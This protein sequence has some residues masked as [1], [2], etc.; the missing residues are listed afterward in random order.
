MRVLVIE[1]VLTVVDVGHREHDALQ[2]EHDTN[3]RRVM[4]R[5]PGSC[6]PRNY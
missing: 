3:A 1:V 6:V 4:I 2:R 5:A